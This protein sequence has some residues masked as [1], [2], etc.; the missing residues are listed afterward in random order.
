ML[1]RAG[2]SPLTAACTDI[3]I[4]GEVYTGMMVVGRQPIQYWLLHANSL[5]F[6]KCSALICGQT[7]GCILVVLVQNQLSLKWPTESEPG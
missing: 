2:I 6:A 3:D 4:D 5:S 7:P 1:N